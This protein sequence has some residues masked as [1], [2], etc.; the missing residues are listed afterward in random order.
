MSDTKKSNAAIACGDMKLK[1]DGKIVLLSA[2]KEELEEL[3][4]IRSDFNLIK[5]YHTLVNGKKAAL[6][7]I[8]KQY[9]RQGT[10]RLKP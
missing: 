5:S 8:Q 6:Y 9:D 1:D 2:R 10:F 4:K 7:L 3:L